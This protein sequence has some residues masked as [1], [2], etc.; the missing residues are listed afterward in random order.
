MTKEQI[1]FI[2]ANEIHFEHVIDHNQ[3]PPSSNDIA[4]QVLAI[5]KELTGK[6][7]DCCRECIQEAYAE[8]W[9]QYQLNPQPNGKSKK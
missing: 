9:K 1:Q 5:Y 7:A 8:V 3:V 2:T 4:M 6:E